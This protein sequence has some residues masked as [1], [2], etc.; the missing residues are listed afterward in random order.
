MK[1]RLCCFLLVTF[2]CFA[3]VVEGSH[4][5]KHF[6]EQILS[7][8][9]ALMEE[10]LTVM[11]V[12]GASLGIVMDGEVMVAK[13]Y[14]HRDVEQ[15]LPVT[16]KT[17]FPIGSNTKPFTTFLLGQLVDEGV[18]NWDDPVAMHIPHFKLKCPYTT[19]EITIRDYLTHMSGYPRYDAM[20]YNSGFSRQEVIQR[21]R[22][23]E[24]IATFRE[25]FI[26][27]NLGYM[28][29]AHAAENA[30]G[31][32]WEDLTKE[33]ILGPLAMTHTNFTIADLKKCPDH[34]VGCKEN[35]KGE[36]CF[37]SYIDVPQIAPAGALNSNTEDMIKWVKTLLKKGNGLV[38]ENTWNEIISPQVVSNLVC[39]GRYGVEGIIQM[40]S[41]CLG[42]T[43]IS[44][45]GHIIL[46]HGGN[47]DGFSSSVMIMPQDGIGMVILTNKHMSPLPYIFATTLIDRMLGMEK[48]DWLQKFKTF[49]DYTKETF[50]KDQ[51][52]SNMERHENTSPSHPLND[53][54]GTYF[55]P[56]YGP[57]E[58]KAKDGQLEAIFRH[59]SLPLKHWHYDVF[60]VTEDAKN[61]HFV[62][63]KFTFNENERGDIHSFQTSFEPLAEA[64]CFLKQKDEALFHAK[65]L[66]RFAGNYSYLGIGFKIELLSSKL[67]V[68]ATGQPPFELMPLKDSVFAVKGFDGYIV[69]FISNPQGQVNTVQCILP[70]KTSYTASRY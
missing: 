33:K 30:T 17:L 4:R 3:N 15:K 24:P 42:W 18:L 11:K 64:A 68:K 19:S 23:L 34:A 22:Y 69:Q 53:F 47:I 25:K 12:P 36:N 40:E 52:W 56:A 66:E 37:I 63:L 54:E 49:T 67:Y 59:D 5:I 43:M 50:Q 20:W 55:H 70:N 9:D 28:I 26:Y 13:G 27:Q 38:Q 62:G 32:T 21:L 45:R 51:Q 14:G 2:S 10:C 46:I 41:Y 29:A 8:V 16:T 57:I 35:R 44:Y 39:N 61:S 60:E 58:I 1:K 31:K 7:D 6:Q 65:Y 48:I